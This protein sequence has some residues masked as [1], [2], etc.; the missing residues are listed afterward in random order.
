MKQLHPP[1]PYFK[2]IKAQFS[3]LIWQWGIATYFIENIP[4]EYSTSRLFADQLTQFYIKTLPA[5][6]SKNDHHHIYEFGAGMGMLA[7]H[8]VEALKQ[9]S[10]HHTL[11][12]FTLHASE[13]SQAQID[14]INRYG[15]LKN[16]G[17][18]IQLDLI[19]ALEPQFS[20]GTPNWIYL[21]YLVAALPARQI[22]VID[23]VIYERYIEASLPEEA[24][25]TDATQ[26]PPKV[27]NADDIIALIQGKDQ[28]KIHYLIP[29]ISP[30]IQENEILIPL[31]ETNDYAIGEAQLLKDF[32][33][34]N[35]SQKGNYKFNFPYQWLKAMQT[36]TEALAEEGTLV[37]FDF[38][39]NTLQDNIEWIRLFG[40]FGTSQYT[41]VSFPLLKWVAEKQGCHV[42][43]TS[44][45]EGH[46][47]HMVIYKGKTPQKIKAAFNEI[48]NPQSL[49]PRAHQIVEE[50][51][52]TNTETPIIVS[53]EKAERWTQELTPLEE[54]GYS[55]NAHISSAL[56]HHGFYDE[57][58][59]YAQ[60]ALTDYADVGISALIVIARCYLKKSQPELALPYLEKIKEIAPQYHVPDCELATI[61]LQ[62]NNLYGYISHSLNWTQRSYYPFSWSLL[63]NVAI[64]AYQIADYQL[65][66]A[67][68]D[69]TIA[70]Y[71]KAPDLITDT[72][73]SKARMI[74]KAVKSLSSCDAKGNIHLLEKLI[75]NIKEQW[76]NL[77]GAEDI[78]RMLTDRCQDIESG[79]NKS[80]ILM[81]GRT[82]V[83]WAWIES[84]GL[85]YG[86]IAMHTIHPEYEPHLAKASL[87]AGMFENYWLHELIK[88]KE[89]T[90]YPESFEYFG[91]QKCSRDR[92]VLY[93]EYYTPIKIS[94]PRLTFKQITS[95]ELPILS[96][97]AYQAHQISQDQF[98]AYDMATREGRVELDKC[99][100]DG[101]FGHAIP[102]ANIMAYL[103]GEP[104][105]YYGTVDVKCWGFDH[106][107]W[108]FDIGVSP[109]F[110][111]LGIGKIL[112]AHMLNTLKQDNRF[113]LVGLAVTQ[114]NYNA[115]H[116]YTQFGFQKVG[117]FDEFGLPL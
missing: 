102:E 57:A 75:D 111:G 48:W 31:Q 45:P 41:S 50:I 86:N 3:S 17:D 70:A 85:H 97:M 46:S 73:K 62:K 11:P 55:V 38:G 22:C 42:E 78:D 90:K 66:L 18:C 36:M 83:G 7:K 100:L 39:F 30:L 115:I 6:T 29:L 74:Q 8:V 64:S 40:K 65:A 81:D 15:F 14:D 5:P 76:K 34:Q 98:L 32:V 113:E 117:E 61:E 47:Q 79:K 43:L 71:A 110:Q 92:M 10:Q 20:Q 51:W 93:L 16:H 108:I 13:Y 84:V 106:V 99:L 12:Q 21:S 69:A 116:I 72:L 105:G 104:A 67:C 109:K 58:I 68:A 9:K 33:A 28:S 77:Q 107:P 63:L 114:N 87:D 103:D 60:K 95:E 19:S 26:F 56:F 49:N 44:Q 53:P 82:A 25:I 101:T 24:V 2:S 37:I 112:M 35:I 89:K 54:V 96:E 1:I 80:I 4:F 91:I 94:E 27:L 52:S 88:F 23:G 59:N